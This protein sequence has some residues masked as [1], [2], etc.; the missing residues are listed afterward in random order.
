MVIILNTPNSCFV[1]VPFVKKLQHTPAVRTGYG[2]ENSR[3]RQNCD[4]RCSGLVGKFGLGKPKTHETQLMVNRQENISGGVSVDGVFV[5]A[6]RCQGDL[7]PGQQSVL[8]LREVQTKCTRCETAGV[9][10]DVGCCVT[11]A[12]A[13]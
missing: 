4:A 9:P 12:H 3:E 7:T 1:H 6:E 11:R 10:T 2:L 8:K 13:Q 5:L